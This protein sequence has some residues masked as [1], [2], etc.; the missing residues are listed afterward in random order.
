MFLHLPNEREVIRQA[1]AS[2]RFDEFR[3]K[4]GEKWAST[5]GPVAVCCA[6]T[7]KRFGYW[8]PHWC[9]L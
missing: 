5:N 2:T 3:A 9:S 8:A 6:S 4:E 1:V 7:L